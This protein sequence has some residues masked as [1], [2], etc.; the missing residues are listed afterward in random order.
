MA[1]LVPARLSARSRS[2]QPIQRVTLPTAHQ[3][4][5]L[6]PGVVIMANP[7]SGV[8]H[9]RRRVG[10]LVAALRSEGLE[11]RPLWHPGEL[12]E[13][14]ADPNFTASYRAVVAAGGD[15]TL[16]HVINHETRVPV[17][18]FP[19]G[20]EN[21]FARQF[22]YSSDP[23]A[24]AT[25]IAAGRTRTIDLGRA[26]RQRFS[27]VATAGFDGDVIH[28][29]AHWRRRATR[30]KRVRGLT[31]VRP[32]L[33]SACRYRYP[34][35]ELDADGQP[36]QGALAMIFNLP[37][38][39]GNLQLA[40]AAIGDDGLLDWLLFERPGSFRLAGYALWVLLGRHRDRPDVQHGRARR[41]RLSCHDPVPLEI[42]GE[43]AGFTPAEI[44][45]LPSAL[46]VIVP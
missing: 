14:S 28:R 8:R 27:V 6:P 17:M 22:G 19:L 21:L 36:F 7:Y 3:P 37:Q 31:Y 5:L 34:L 4:D 33:A 15:G 24:A 46:R 1:G 44:Q 12:A 32:I 2:L 43:A 29:L 16:N 18:M 40:P 25:A 11:A 41:V 13:L 38:Y 45:V 35:V 39:C 10:D 26:G 23:A 20:N 42:D 9:N 30:L